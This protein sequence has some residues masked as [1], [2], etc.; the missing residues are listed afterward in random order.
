MRYTCIFLFFFLL[1]IILTIFSP[2]FSILF[3]GRIISALSCSLLIILCFVMA[4]RIVEPKYRGRAIAIVS[5]GVS[6]SIALGVPVG[7]ML[8]EAFNW[9]APFVLV[10]VLT[11]LSMVGVHFLMER[12]SPS[13][14]VPLKKQL[15]S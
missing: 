14:A 4:P 6:G 10:A 2:T 9:R 7:L 11:I 13:L 8:G 3:F 12:V 15:A 1:R 5:M